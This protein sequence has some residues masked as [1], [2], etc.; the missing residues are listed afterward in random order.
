MTTEKRAYLLP[1][2]IDPDDD[3]CI[4][5]YI[6]NDPIYIG[7]FWNA[8][9]YFTKWGAWERDDAHRGVEAASRWLSSF[10]QARDEW[11]LGLG[12]CCPFIPVSEEPLDNLADLL[13]SIKEVFEQI[14]N[15]LDD[16]YTA[17]QIKGWMT[18]YIQRFPGLADAIDAMS[19][20]T[21]VDRQAALN[22]FDW[23][24]AYDG[25]WCDDSCDLSDYTGAFGFIGWSECAITKFLSYLE[26]QIDEMSEWVFT[27]F[28]GVVDW[29]GIPWL[30][31]MTPAG[32]LNFDF[33][34]PVCPFTHTWD[35]SEESGDW[36][37]DW[38]PGFGG[39]WGDGQG[40]LPDVRQQP[41]DNQWR[42]SYWL[43]R[44][45]TG[46]YI[47]S[48][49]VNVT[50]DKGNINATGASGFII[51]GTLEGVQQGYVSRTFSQLSNGTWEYTYVFDD[52]C[53]RLEVY[54]ACSRHATE[55]GATSGSV[56]L[57]SA[58]VMGMGDDPF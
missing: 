57:N 38:N 24:S 11:L 14:D 10:E 5:V 50:L 9:E 58:V 15:W 54:T 12:A 17:T 52:E 46:T 36:V 4:R 18:N 6:P 40:W 53:D 43:Y 48:L 19:L 23:Q 51:K 45:F 30:S 29:A 47:T 16:G 26:V 34:T 49:K 42:K 33:I 2:D 55:A 56:V 8:Y 1:E 22:A 39:H 32:G 27:G 31:S 44:E 41:D 7:A 37:G 35:F 13:W 3:L 25:I 28:D 21:S 20:E